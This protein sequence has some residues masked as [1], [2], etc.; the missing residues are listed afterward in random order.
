MRSYRCLTARDF[1]NR[2][3]YLFVLLM[4]SRNLLPPDGLSS[5]Q[6]LLA[7]VVVYI[8]QVSIANFVDNDE[9]GILRGRC[10]SLTSFLTNPRFVNIL[11][12]NCRPEG[13]F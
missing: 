4:F 11:E 1:K 13:L 7:K 5:F 8:N 3:I 10:V 6:C 9:I 12:R 2:I